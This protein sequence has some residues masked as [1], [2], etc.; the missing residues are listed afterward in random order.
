MK[1]YLLS[2][3]AEIDWYKLPD[4]DNEHTAKDVAEALRTAADE[5]EEYSDWKIGR[6]TA[7]NDPVEL[8][9]TQS[10]DARIMNAR[11][12]AVAAEHFGI[13]YLDIADV[14]WTDREYVT[15]DF[16]DWAL[17]TLVNGDPL[18]DIVDKKSYGDW[19]KSMLDAGY[20]LLAP[21][22]LDDHNEF[23]VIPEFGLGCRTTKV[24]FFKRKGDRDGE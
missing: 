8:D 11:I 12:L 18:E 24:R 1:L 9:V 23:C 20:D 6:G 17:C 21:D 13:K 4:V 10:P 19:A 7:G 16:P 5:L 3:K 14:S 22:V 15:V 2:F